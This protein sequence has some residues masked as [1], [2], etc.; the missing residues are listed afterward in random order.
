MHKKPIAN[1][2]HERGNKNNGVIAGARR[3]K[4]IYIFLRRASQRK[5]QHLLTFRE[6]KHSKLEYKKGA[7][8]ALPGAFLDSIGASPLQ[9]DRAQDDTQ[10]TRAWKSC[11]RRRL[12]YR[13]R[14]P[15]SGPWRAS[16]RSSAGHTWHLPPGTHGR[17]SARRTRRQNR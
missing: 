8:R 12:R 4:H 17:P 15:R 13:S 14:Q 5:S 7:P 6:T 16:A 11:N 2:G 3:H 9:N 1:K 10:T